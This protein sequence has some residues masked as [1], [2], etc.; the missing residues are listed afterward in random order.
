VALSNP[1][2][3][4]E[5]HHVHLTEWRIH[6]YSKEKGI[7]KLLKR[8]EGDPTVRSKVMALSKPYAD[9]ERHD[10]HLIEWR[11]HIYSKENCIW[12]LL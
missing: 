7:P 9:L 10:L 12:I 4:L 2:A 11:F 8:F 5:R 3:D 1:Y 6:I